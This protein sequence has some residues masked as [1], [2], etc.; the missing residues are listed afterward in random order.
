MRNSKIPQK[1]VR[2]LQS[3][4]RCLEFGYEAIALTILAIH[5]CFQFLKSIF[6]VKSATV[7]WKNHSEIR[8]KF[9][10]KCYLKLF[11]MWL[12][13][14]KPLRSS[15]WGPAARVVCCSSVL[16]FRK[17]KELK[18]EL[19]MHDLGFAWMP[20]FSHELSGKAST[21]APALNKVIIHSS[22]GEV[23]PVEQFYLYVHSA[24]SIQWHFCK[25]CH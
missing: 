6:F 17:G 18:N 7:Q 16:A 23:S 5:L 20:F 13:R 8:K 14:N 1:L 10:I 11:W 24:I 19:L 2:S 22:G 25:D 12:W 15:E 3:N 21:R 9:P 4:W